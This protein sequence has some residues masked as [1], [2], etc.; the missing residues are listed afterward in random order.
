[1]LRDSHDRGTDIVV[2]IVRIPVLIDVETV[3]EIPVDI[4]RVTVVDFVFLPPMIHCPPIH[5]LSRN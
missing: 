5:L 1:M 4:E 3:V 2:G